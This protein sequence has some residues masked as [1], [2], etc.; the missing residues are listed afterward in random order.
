M[1][2]PT[3]I[4][5][6]TGTKNDDRPSTPTSKIMFGL[7]KMQLFTKPGAVFW[8]LMGLVFFILSDNAQEQIRLPKDLAEG[9]NLTMIFVYVTQ[10]FTVLHGVLLMEKRL[11]RMFTDSNLKRPRYLAF[12]IAPLIIN[13]LMKIFSWAQMFSLMHDT[14]RTAFL[15]LNL[16][17]DIANDI[18]ILFFMAIPSFIIGVVANTF[19]RECNK[20]ELNPQTAIA[21]TTM[22]LGTYKAFQQGAEYLIF[23]QFTMHTLMVISIGCILTVSSSCMSFNPVLIALYVVT[24]VLSIANLCYIA[25]VL[26]DCQQCL[27]DIEDRLRDVYVKTTDHQQGRELLVLLQ[28]MAQQGG[29]SGLGFFTVDRSTL[30]AELGTILTYFVVLWQ[31]DLC[32]PANQEMSAAA[33]ISEDI[34]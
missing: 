10:Y 18:L 6:L 11:P 13:A 3:K 4:N 27:K 24:M 12:M 19:I 30:M 22:K 32:P 20:E 23:S 14:E 34:A 1:L 2:G 9:V 7:G 28:R 33:N 25:I 17:K 31:A 15:V 8:S 21:A 26:D 5:S 29:F 16:A